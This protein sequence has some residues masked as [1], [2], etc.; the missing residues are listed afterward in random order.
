L[1][2]QRIIEQHPPRGRSR[3]IGWLDLL[4]AKRTVVLRWRLLGGRFGFELLRRCGFRRL[5]IRPDC[6]CAEPEAITN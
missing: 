1:I 2:E 5:V 4:P 6:T 3:Q